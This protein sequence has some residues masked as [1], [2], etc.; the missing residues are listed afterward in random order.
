MSY[1][2]GSQIKVGDKVTYTEYNEQDARY[3]YSTSRQISKVK[4]IREYKV[5]EIVLENGAVKNPRTL[6]KVAS[7]GKRR[8]TRKN[9]RKH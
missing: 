5:Y 6:T 9:T 3:G 4:E 7:G 8:K 2:D 1:Q